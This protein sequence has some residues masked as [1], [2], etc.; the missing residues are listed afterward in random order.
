M[1][2]QVCMSVCERQRSRQRGRAHPCVWVCVWASSSS[3]FPPASA[4]SLFISCCSRL[5]F[6]FPSSLPHFFINSIFSVSQYFLFFHHLNPFQ[7]PLFILDSSSF[8]CA[9]LV[10]LVQLRQMEGN[11]LYVIQPIYHCLS[12]LNQKASFCSI[13]TDF[14]LFLLSPVPFL[15]PS[16]QMHE[17]NHNYMSYFHYTHIYTLLR[18]PHCIFFLIL[19][20]FCFSALKGHT[21][22]MYHTWTH[23]IWTTACL[24]SSLPKTSLCAPRK[25]THIKSL[26][27]R[28]EFSHSLSCFQTIVWATAEAVGKEFTALLS[29]LKET[30]TDYRWTSASSGQNN[31]RPLHYK[32]YSLYECLKGFF[33]HKC[34]SES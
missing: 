1:R 34:Q 4:S 28:A 27:P 9:V 21:M 30:E 8:H 7:A 24:H 33:H 3:L 14:L 2:W 10:F 12:F 6:T 23:T 22:L 26:C 15:L 13:N 32:K 11:V 16:W 18:G 17:G 19:S 5:L 29:R 20:F 25:H 31:N